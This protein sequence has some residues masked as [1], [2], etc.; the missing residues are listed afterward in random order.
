MHPI[1]VLALLLVAQVPPTVGVSTDRTWYAP[2]DQVQVTITIFN[3]DLEQLWVYV[4]GPDG[5]NLYFNRIVPGNLTA[6]IIF[7]T[8]PGDL[9]DG[10]CTITVTW[11]HEYVQTGFI[12]ETQP[13]P[14]F[15][16][17]PL[18]FV[19]AFTIATLALARRK[20]GARTETA[21]AHS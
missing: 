3:S 19:F 1:L 7:V 20:A 18:V 16:A 8:L 4:D 2:G 15:P 13:I 10:M 9:A 5:R 21:A 17:A 11:D 14:E 6:F 12:V